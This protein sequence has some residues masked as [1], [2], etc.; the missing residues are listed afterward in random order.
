M[1]VAAYV[2]AFLAGLA[3]LFALACEEHYR[4]Q[5]NKEETRSRRDAEDTRSTDG[6]G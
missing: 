2:V 5:I 6:R 3:V 4:Q 1:I